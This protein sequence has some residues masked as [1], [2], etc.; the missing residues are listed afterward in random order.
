MG[1]LRAET[2]LLIA[3]YRL[4][5]SMGIN[6]RSSVAEKERANNFIYKALPSFKFHNYSWH[7]YRFLDLYD[8]DYRQIENDLRAGTFNDITTLAFADLEVDEVECGN[9]ED[10]GYDECGECYGDGEHQCSNCSGDGEVYCRECDG[11]GEYDEERCETCDGSGYVKC[12][13]CSGYGKVECDYCEET[14]RIICNYCDG[15]NE[16]DILA[17]SE[18]TLVVLKHSDLTEEM[19]T[20]IDEVST[21]ITYDSFIDLLKEKSIP[22]R[23]ITYNSDDNIVGLNYSDD[24][25]YCFI[26]YVGLEFDPKKI[27]EYKNNKYL[28]SVE[29]NDLVWT[30]VTDYVYS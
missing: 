19:S 28:V 29:H 7:I 10:N 20:Y 9:C 17:M 5:N 14:G 8:N 11:N 18:I 21:G 6:S 12:D 1:L 2:N 27:S 26:N 23:E 30:D 24:A 15:D 22:H 4:L 3:T 16:G 25:Y 13:E